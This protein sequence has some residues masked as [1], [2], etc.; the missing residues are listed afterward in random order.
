MKSRILNFCGI[1]MVFIAICCAFESLVD[2]TSANCASDAKAN[3]VWLEYSY[4]NNS[5]ATCS[6]CN[7]FTSCQLGGA[8][9]AGTCT[10][11]GGSDG[12]QRNG[13]AKG[14]CK[15]SFYQICLY[16]DNFC[17]AARK[18]SCVDV[19]DEEN[20]VVGCAVGPCVAGGGANC[21]GC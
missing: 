10:G 16:V 8:G 20:N 6:G 9:G 4:C 14:T 11:F 2:G 15:F 13:I 18:P 12:C 5:G 21:S 1:G 3:A 17:G 19:L 7:P